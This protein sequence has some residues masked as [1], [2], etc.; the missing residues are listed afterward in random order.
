[1]AWGKS[2]RSIE[3]SATSQI[4][5]VTFSEHHSRLEISCNGLGRDQVGIV[6]TNANISINPNPLV[7]ERKLSIICIND[8]IPS[9]NVLIVSTGESDS[10]S[11]LEYSEK[12]DLLGL[13]TQDDLI[14]RANWDES[15]RVSIVG[16]NIGQTKL[17]VFINHASRA[18][19]ANFTSAS[20]SHLGV[21]IDAYVSYGPFVLV[22]LNSSTQIL[23]LGNSL[24]IGAMPKSGTSVSPKHVSVSW[25]STESG[26]VS[27]SDIFSSKV[28]GKQNGLGVK[29]E[30]VLPGAA[31]LD[32]V[33][34]YSSTFFSRDFL[35]AVGKQHLNFTV[36][37]TGRLNIFPQSNS[38]L[39]IPLN[40]R[41]VFKSDRSLSPLAQ[42]ISNVS[43]PGLSSKLSPSGELL[44]GSREEDLLVSFLDSFSSEHFLVFVRQIGGI[45]LRHRSSTSSVFTSQGAL[46]VRSNESR[47]EVDVYLR[48]K[49]GNEFDLPFGEERDFND[50]FLI[51]VLPDNAAVVET[52][53]VLGRRAVSSFVLKGFANTSLIEEIAI[54][55]EPTGRWKNVL[56]PFSA[57]LLVDSLN[58]ECGTPNSLVLGTDDSRAISRRCSYQGFSV[59]ET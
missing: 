34:E 59:K 53:S 11:F 15:G 52:S 29:V 57:S 25:P 35:A 45:V 23:P 37:C 58:P 16:K 10:I 2:R 8:L 31:R 1:M 24:L 5:L 17:F 6:M 55:V 4:S 3:V 28:Y 48:D 13:I 50:K 49:M 40:T 42:R 20:N 21:Y 54:F 51:R 19:V 36:L 30:G 18:I 14:C 27:L 22:G 33:I 38:G 7:Y 47:L 9:S 12:S 26:I 41:I 39:R 43:S 44:T 56:T 46:C 32:V